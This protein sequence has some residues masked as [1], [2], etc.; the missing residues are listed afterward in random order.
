MKEHIDDSIYHARQFLQEL[1]K[2]QNQYY[3]KIKKKFKKSEEYKL[4]NLRN[5]Y[6]ALTGKPLTIIHDENQLEDFFW[7][8]MFNGDTNGDFFEYIM[9]VQLK[10]DEYEK[11]IDTRE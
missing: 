7:D 3:N 2:V 11:R 6:E 10:G 9:D 4:K 5:E 1:F 8:Y